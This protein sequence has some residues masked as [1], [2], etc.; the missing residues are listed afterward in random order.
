MKRSAALY[1]SQKSIQHAGYF[2]DLFENLIDRC[3]R[4]GELDRQFGLA[5]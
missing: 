2:M 3:F 5:P 1:L 4:K